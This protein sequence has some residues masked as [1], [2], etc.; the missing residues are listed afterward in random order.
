LPSGSARPRRRSTRP[1]AS[2]AHARRRCA[3]SPCPGR[4]LRPQKNRSGQTIWFSAGHEIPVCNQM[5]LKRMDIFQAKTFRGAT[6]LSTERSRAAAQSPSQR[7]G[8][9]SGLGEFENVSLGHGVSLLR[10]RSG[11]SKHPQRYAALPLDAVTNVRPQPPLEHS[12]EL[13]GVIAKIVKCTVPIRACDSKP[14]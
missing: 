4:A 9:S 11:G 5:N 12:G 6:K 10:W 13:L 2:S 14:P 7:I 8:K 3:P 1:V